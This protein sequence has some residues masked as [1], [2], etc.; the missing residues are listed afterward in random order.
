MENQDWYE[1]IFR[2]ALIHAKAAAKTTVGGD[3]V[4]MRAALSYVGMVATQYSRVTGKEFD[5]RYT[6]LRGDSGIRLRLYD[7]A[8]IRRPTAISDELPANG[9]CRQVYQTSS[10]H[11]LFQQNQ[12]PETS[13]E[14]GP[15]LQL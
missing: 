5:V 15:C 2:L 9:S 11:E 7:T 10:L 13:Q 8:V 1:A 4:G 6:I 12:E 3:S 14:D